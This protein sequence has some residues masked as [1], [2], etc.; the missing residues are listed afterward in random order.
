MVVKS[1]IYL[2]I[3]FSCIMSH[4][5]LIAWHWYD[6][7][8]SDFDTWYLACHHLTPDILSSDWLLT[9]FLAHIICTVAVILYSWILV[10]SDTPELCA[11]EFLYLLYLQILLYS[12]LTDNHDQ[13]HKVLNST[14][15]GET[16]GYRYDVIFIM[17]DISEVLCGAR[18][19][20]SPEAG[21]IFWS[22][23]WGA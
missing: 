12:S 21:V 2:I 13:L 5:L 9:L 22:V 17:V 14:G 1:L 18:D 11:P 16:D 23:V 15:M 7:L 3:L 6:Y 10:S 19:E 4:D 20:K 8:I